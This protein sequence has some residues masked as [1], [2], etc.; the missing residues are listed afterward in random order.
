LF[1]A[2]DKYAKTSF[3]IAF[4]L[5]YKWERPYSKGHIFKSFFSLGSQSG[6]VLTPMRGVYPVKA[7]LRT[8]ILLEAD[9]MPSEIVVMDERSDASISA[10]PHL[11]RSVLLYGDD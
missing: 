2:K 8:D 6:R 5:I 4:Q 11:P 10:R 3:E 9:L 7:T 1:L